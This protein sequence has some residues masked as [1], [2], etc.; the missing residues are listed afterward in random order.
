[1]ITYYFTLPGGTGAMSLEANDITEARKR[2]RAA[3]YPSK[4]RLPK[5][6]EIWDPPQRHDALY[7]RTTR[8]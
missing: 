3:W 1:M 5:G 8:R 2:I 6:V 7:E 4:K